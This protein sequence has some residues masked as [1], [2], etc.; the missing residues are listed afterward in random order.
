MEVKEINDKEKIVF[1]DK[2]SLKGPLSEKLRYI[3]H[4]ADN[5]PEQPGYCFVFF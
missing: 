5:D 1:F 4:L 2:D 3:E